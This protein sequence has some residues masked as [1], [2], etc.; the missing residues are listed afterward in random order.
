MSTI[1]GHK[2]AEL[3]A[4][5]GLER[6]VTVKVRTPLDLV[7]IVDRHVEA[8]GESRAAFIRRAMVEMMII[9]GIR[10]EA[11]RVRGIDTKVLFPYTPGKPEGEATH[12]TNGT[13]ET[14]DDD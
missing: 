5:L 10:A 8:T 9:D 12:G 7:E 2:R 3:E 13:K 4:L 11:A 1:C 6:D 14:E